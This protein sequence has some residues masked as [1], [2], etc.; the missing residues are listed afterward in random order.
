ME[1]DDSKTANTHFAINGGQVSQREQWTQSML[2]GGICKDC[3][4]GW[5]SKLEVNVRPP[6]IGLLASTQKTLSSAETKALAIW[7]FKTAIV[8]NLAMNYRQIVPDKQFK[9]LYDT[10]EIPKYVYV[11]IASCPHHSGLSGIQSQT[12][13][14]VFRPEDVNNIHAMCINAYNIILAIGQILLRVISFPHPQYTVEIPNSFM[15][16]ARRLYPES[17]CSLDF[18]QHCT[19]PIDFETEAWIVAQST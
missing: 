19:H 11:D 15:G 3:N 9:Q 5:M 8:R 10:Q 18:T 12:F 13:I 4:G 14:G 7:A 1:L 6:L 17:D 16:G 2:A